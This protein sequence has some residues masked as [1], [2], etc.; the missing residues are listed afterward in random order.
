MRQY[1]VRRALLIVP[2]ILGVTLLVSGLLELLQ[3][4]IADVIFA[5]SATFNQE[6]TKEQIE[7]DLGTN[8]N[9]LVQW[10]EWLGGVVQGDFGEYFRGGKSVGS[11]L[12][13][14]VPVTL[15]LSFMALVLSL[16][17]ALPIGVV[18]ALRQD[19]MVDHASRSVSIFMLAAPSFLLGTLFFVFA[20]RWAGWLLPPLN[21]VDFWED[22][23]ANFQKMWVPPLFLPSGCPARS[24]D[25]HAA[26]C[27]RC[28]ARTTSGLP[29]PR[30]CVSAPS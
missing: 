11:E 15:E 30:A 29:G 13:L 18:S 2:T 26:R 5:E 6:L 20:G 10:A 8:E 12:K 3:G 7:E 9:F 17:I 14:R 21:Y 4:D 23:W 1:F 22:P 25:S 16:F 27:S 19:T 24:C 28:C